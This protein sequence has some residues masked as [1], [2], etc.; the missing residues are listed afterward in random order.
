MTARLRRLAPT[1]NPTLRPEFENGLN[2]APTLFLRALRALNLGINQKLGGDGRAGFY[3][4]HNYLIVFKGNLHTET[5]MEK[6]G[7]SLWIA[8]GKRFRGNTQQIYPQ[9]ANG[10]PTLDTQDPAR[11]RVSIRGAGP[12]PG[13]TGGCFKLPILPR[14][15]CLGVASTPE[16]QC[17][18]SVSR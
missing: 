1:F 5:P 15:Q 13:S 9:D 6:P 14:M 12:A 18:S 3:V 8:V 4:K 2:T 10:R 17:T 16:H 7:K 11:R